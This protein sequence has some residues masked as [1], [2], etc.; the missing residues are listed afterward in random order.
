MEQRVYLKI[1]IQDMILFVFPFLWNGANEKLQFSLA[2][3]NFISESV[4]NF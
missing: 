2:Y 4:K 3:V 1:S